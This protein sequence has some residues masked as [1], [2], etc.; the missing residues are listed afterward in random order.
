MLPNQMSLFD[1]VEDA[2]N[3]YVCGKEYQLLNLLTPKNNRLK[4]YINH[5]PCKW[6]D[7]SADITENYF[8]NQE[9]RDQYLDELNQVCGV[10][11]NGNNLDG[12]HK[13]DDHQDNKFINW[14]RRLWSESVWNTENPNRGKILEEIIETEKQEQ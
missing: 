9:D 11:K 6:Y 4:I 8:L 12:W 14:I 7:P 2:K 3:I 10:D 1:V 5:A 13:C